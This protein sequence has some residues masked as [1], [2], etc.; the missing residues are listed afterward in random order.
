MIILDMIF[1]LYYSWD[2]VCYVCLQA[3]TIQSAIGYHHSIVVVLAP[4]TATV[5]DLSGCHCFY[6]YAIFLGL[7]KQE[8]IINYIPF[9]H[10]YLV[11]IY[12]QTLMVRGAQK[13]QLRLRYI[14][15]HITTSQYIIPY[16]ST[17]Y[18][19][20]QY[21]TYLGYARL[22]QTL[23]SRSQTLFSCGPC[24]KGAPLARG[25]QEKRVWLRETII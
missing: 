4:V 9:E 22:S 11:A 1:L 8:L 19:T 25:P 6:T 24:A 12:H 15:Y 21:T 14:I 2:L 3:R 20:S 10:I 16:H 18:T 17:S 7:C 23:V 5:K 13:G